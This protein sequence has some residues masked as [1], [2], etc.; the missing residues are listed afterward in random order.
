MARGLERPFP[1]AHRGEANRL[2][3]ADAKR[4]DDGSLESI[5]RLQLFPDDSHV[6]LCGNINMIREVQ[7]L[8]VVALLDDLAV[9]HDE[10]QV[11]VA[12]R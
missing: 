10:D 2:H 7:E 6:M 5:A 9:L 8:L 3:R 4:L 12:D 1:L 11:C